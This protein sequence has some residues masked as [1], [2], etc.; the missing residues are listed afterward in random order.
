MGLHGHVTRLPNLGFLR[1]GVGRFAQQF[2]YKFFDHSFLVRGWPTHR[3]NWLHPQPNRSSM[4]HP[5][6][7]ANARRRASGL[8]ATGTDSLFQQRQVVHGVRIKGG[9][10]GVPVQPTR[11]QPLLHP[12]D[13]ALAK[14]GHTANG[15]GVP[16]CAIRPSKERSSS[17]AISS[18]DT[19]SLCNGSGHKFVGGGDD[20]HHVT[21]ILVLAHQFQAPGFV[22]IS[23]R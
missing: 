4:R 7:W 3:C 9:V 12:G 18:L 1:P 8:V 15:A 13:L 22:W 6:C 2:V 19:K 5:R 14:G 17:T 11:L 20:G 23:G 21:G 10:G 16:A